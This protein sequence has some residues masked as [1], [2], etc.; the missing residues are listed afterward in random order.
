MPNEVID[1]Y[2]FNY[3]TYIDLVKTFMK[4]CKRWSE[5]CK[6]TT[7][8]QKHLELHCSV[9]NY[10]KRLIIV[11][12]HQPTSL[13]LSLSY[14]SRHESKFVIPAIVEASERL[15]TLILEIDSHCPVDIYPAKSLHRITTLVIGPKNLSQPPLTNKRI[16]TLFP[17]LKRLQIHSNEALYEDTAP[18][19][20]LDELV[21]F[22]KLRPSGEYPTIPVQKFMLVSGCVYPNLR[23][24]PIGDSYEEHFRYYGVTQFSNALTA[25]EYD[26]AEKLL[27]NKKTSL[28]YE[29][30]LFY[31]LEFAFG[32]NLMA[33]KTSFLSS[34]VDLNTFNNKKAVEFYLDK[35]KIPI[36]NALKF[37]AFV[38]LNRIDE[39]LTVLQ[40]ITKTEADQVKEEFLDI[41]LS[42]KVTVKALKERSL[43]EISKII[44]AKCPINSLE[45][46]RKIALV[47]DD[48]SGV[49][50]N[51][52]NTEVF[53]EMVKRGSDID[54]EDLHMNLL[55]APE[56]YLG[57]L[58]RIM[59][60]NPL[61]LF[62]FLPY[63]KISESI[64]MM[65]RYRLTPTMEN[66][67]RSL[68]NSWILLMKTKSIVKAERHLLQFKHL[69]NH[70]DSNGDTPLC[71]AVAEREDAYDL[72]NFLLG[73]GADPNLHRADKMSPI[74][75]TLDSIQ[76]EFDHGSSIL[77]LL[78]QYGADLSA[79]CMFRG[80]MYS[81]LM[82]AVKT[83]LRY[84]ILLIIALGGRTDFKDENGRDVRDLLIWRPSFKHYL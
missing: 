65:Q 82:I 72:V 76:R 31:D 19:K 53:M 14:L 58:D 47:V 21:A 35:K 52:L 2:I 49:K 4:V 39:A 44:L 37:R 11:K 75:M 46:F 33:K 59:I 56:K 60:K 57:V 42:A 8:K 27:D 71:I 62:G 5:I 36:S 48:W 63:Q 1:L 67:G 34:I 51:T 38:K 66:S 50:A 13:H 16:F 17:N 12:R 64:E 41:F 23:S 24:S 9:L 25:H 83:M 55:L 68:F 74:G 69:I 84:T 18:L 54:Y 77:H 45:A 29:E 22:C 20:Q 3:F 28:E 81:P 32:E 79:P 70:L 15:H 26:V 78:L 6:N 40:S 7:M 61:H 80:L 73:F 30:Y 43:I 10:S